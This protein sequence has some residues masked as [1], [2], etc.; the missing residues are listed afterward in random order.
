MPQEQVLEYEVLA[1]TRPGQD[2][3][4]QQPEE[5]EHVLSIADLRPRGD[6]PSHNR[7]ERTSGSFYRRIPL[8]VEV[9]P[10]QVEATMTDGVLEVRIPR[11][12]ES[13]PEARKIPVK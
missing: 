5:F 4:E 1:R 2:R 10:Q 13:K 6:L 9:E 12:A 8:P 7:M 3:R 11:P